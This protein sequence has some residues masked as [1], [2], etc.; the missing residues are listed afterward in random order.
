MAANLPGPF[1]KLSVVFVAVIGTV[2]LGEWLSSQ[3]WVGVALIAAGKCL[4]PIGVSWK[5]EMA[6]SKAHQAPM[7][8]APICNGRCSSITAPACDRVG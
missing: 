8:Q 1:D 7:Q 2:F 6:I 4:L 3:N 5:S